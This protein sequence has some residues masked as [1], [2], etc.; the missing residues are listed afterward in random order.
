MLIAA[1][2]GEGLVGHLNSKGIQAAIIGR[3][4]GSIERLMVHDGK[5]EKIPPP[6]ADELYK[7]I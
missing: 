6:S 5:T 7:V 3:V 1:A 4:N 2:D